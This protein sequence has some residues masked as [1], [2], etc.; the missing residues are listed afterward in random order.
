MSTTRLVV[1]VEAHWISAD[2]M[3]ITRSE[4]K[5]DGRCSQHACNYICIYVH[6][7]HTHTHTQGEVFRRHKECMMT[8]EPV[9][10]QIH[11]MFWVLCSEVFF[12]PM[13]MRTWEVPDVSW[14][15]LFT[16]HREDRWREA[17]LLDVAMSC[18]FAM[19]IYD[20]LL[21]FP[22][23]FP[24]PFPSWLVVF[25]FWSWAACHSCRLSDRVDRGPPS[26][27]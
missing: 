3:C 8:T 22:W 25:C 23:P 7:V 19:I 18:G 6:V 10:H 2:Q 13:K 12:C 5:N 11:R 26:D 27:C 1:A 15:L 14:C 24:T 9:I 21:K 16:L 20:D 4:Q 17:A